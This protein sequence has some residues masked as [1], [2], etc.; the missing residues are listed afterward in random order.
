M[1]RAKNKIE[2]KGPSVPSYIVT[3]SDMVT[4]LLTFFVMLLSLSNTQDQALIDKGKRSFLKNIKNFGVGTLS[5][6]QMSPQFD[7][8]KTKY[9]TDVEKEDSDQRMIDSKE[10]RIRRLYKKLKE[11]M[12]VRPSQ[13]ISQNTDFKAADIYFSSDTTDLNQMSKTNIENF[14]S[15]LKKDPMFEDLKLCIIGLAPGQKNPQQSWVISTKRAQAVA[16]E[17]QRNLKSSSQIPVYNWGAGSGGYWTSS[18]G[19]ASENNQVLISIL[20][21]R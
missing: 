21:P 16:N 8:P 15:K 4:L 5:G 1:S 20:R 10:E 14:C 2:E 17:I 12:Q 6:R 9:H 18:K 19:P 11:S 3:F 7:A 13:I